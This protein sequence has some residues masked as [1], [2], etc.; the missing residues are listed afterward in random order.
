[1]FTKGAS[2]MFDKFR[3]MNIAYR[4]TDE[5]LYSVV[6]QEM[7]NGLRN[8]GLW[9]KALEKADG[10]KE[11]QVSEYIKFRIQSLK[12]DM[13]VLSELPEEKS[14]ILHT[15]DME[16][17]VTLLDNG[18]TL[19]DIK[20]FVS[21]LDLNEL[22]KFIN[23][24]DACDNYPIHIAINKGRDDITR[25]L[26][27]SGADPSLKNYWGKTALSIAESKDDKITIALL[28]QYTR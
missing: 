28:K 26:L 18:S 6:A 16:E 22:S 15:L 17:F 4:K 5:V 10:N 7:E 2:K 12:D 9:L 24:P 14:L 3:K 19:E 21:S 25:W 8:N 27:V 23:Q 13:S 1:M 11:K 20:A